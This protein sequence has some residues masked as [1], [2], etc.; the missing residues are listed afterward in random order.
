MKSFSKTGDLSEG[1]TANLQLT[2]DLQ[3][4]FSGNDATVAC[5][6]YLRELGLTYSSSSYYTYGSSNSPPSRIWM[7]EMGCG[8]TEE[9]LGDCSFNGWGSENCSSGENIG[10]YCYY[11][12]S[13]PRVLAIQYSTPEEADIRLGDSYQSAT[14]HEGRLEV[15]HS[16]TWATVCDDS[17]GTTDAEVA[18]RHYLNSLGLQM[19]DYDYWTFGSTSSA[20]SYIGMDEMNCSGD[21]TSL[22]DCTYP[23]WGSENCSH[24]E[25]TGIRCYFEPF[26]QTSATV[27]T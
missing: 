22:F 26:T 3:E 23:G 1:F 18:C 15:K 8:S 14:Y 11:D 5:R 21:E 19:T 25:D 6:W 10:L 7:D 24:S 27:Y 16:G 20:P 4:G 13:V 12:T 2:L 9:R 17:F